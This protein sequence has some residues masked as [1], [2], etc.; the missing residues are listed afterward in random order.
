MQ[1]LG[2]WIPKPRHLVADRAHNYVRNERFALPVWRLDYTTIYDLHPRQRGTHPGPDDSGTQWIDGTLYPMSLPQGLV[3]IDPIDHDM[4]LDLRERIERRHQA[5]Q[6]YTFVPHEAR[7]SDGL[8]RYRGPA[9]P[10]VR[11]RCLNNPISMRAPHSGPTTPCRLGTRCS[12][13]R[14]VTLWDLDYPDLRM[15]YQHGSLAW[16]ESYFRR[17]VRES[18]R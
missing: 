17:A 7:Q 9:V 16:A 12:C 6:A 8:R 3:E 1:L 4:A 2:D 18:L 13:G 15:P 14:T 11:V 5:R 10:P